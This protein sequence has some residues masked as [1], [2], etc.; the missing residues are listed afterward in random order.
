[1][2]KKTRD[3]EDE[4]RKA[5]VYNFKLLFISSNNQPALKNILICS[6]RWTFFKRTTIHIHLF[7]FFWLSFPLISFQRTLGTTVNIWIS[8]WLNICWDDNF[9]YCMKMSQWFIRYL[10]QWITPSLKIPISTSNILWGEVKSYHALRTNINSSPIKY[11]TSKT[12]P[13]ISSKS[14]LG[15]GVICLSGMNLGPLSLLFIIFIWKCLGTL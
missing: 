12:P 3:P 9:W 2:E 14:H 11:Y 4:V 15:R 6:P 7:L 13:K 5:L 10:S 1:M 8:K